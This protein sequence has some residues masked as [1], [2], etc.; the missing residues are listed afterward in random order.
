M[1]PCIIKKLF[2]HD[3]QSGYK[4][5]KVYNIVGACIGAQG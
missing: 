3:G 1:K 5:P 2:N 4:S